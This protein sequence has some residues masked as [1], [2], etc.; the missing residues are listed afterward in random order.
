MIEG[1]PWAVPLVVL[2]EINMTEV[3]LDELCIFLT[4]ESSTEIANM[5][6]FFFFLLLDLLILGEFLEKS[7]LDRIK[8][9]DF[10]FGL[11]YWFSTYLY[12]ALLKKTLV[13]HRIWN[14]LNLVLC[15]Y[16]EQTSIRFPFKHFCVH[17]EKLITG[18]VCVSK[19]GGRQ[20][21]NTQQHR[22]VLNY[23]FVASLMN[24]GKDSP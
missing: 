9:C 20:E 3:V 6:L 16:S 14:K 17:A 12:R 15:L 2:L 13:V 18:V 4:A 19:R 8:M 21:T 10:T 1:Q 11:I 24:G 22:N 5:S 23:T 7:W